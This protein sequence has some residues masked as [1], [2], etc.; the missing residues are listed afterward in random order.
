MP[1]PAWWGGFRL[2][3]VAFEFWQYAPDRL[4]DRIRYLPAGA[5]W[6]TARLQP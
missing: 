1:R 3:P 4:H 6:G 5:G 2:T